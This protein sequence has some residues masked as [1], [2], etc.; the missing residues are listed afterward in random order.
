LWIQPT[1]EFS[2]EFIAL[3]QKDTGDAS[4]PVQFGGVQTAIGTSTW[5]SFGVRPVYA[6]GEHFKLQGEVGID[7]VTSPTG[8][9]A[10]RLNKVTIAPTITMASGYWARP[11][12]R[13]YV[14]H[15]TW[16]TAAVAAVNAANT[17]PG[18][19]GNATAGTSAGLQLEAWW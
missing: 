1:K 7:N 10:E 19:Y 16:N 14:T 12:L 13:L 5:S 8:G 4:A 9:A 3:M 18:V 11:E 15:A 17:T 6:F 2:A